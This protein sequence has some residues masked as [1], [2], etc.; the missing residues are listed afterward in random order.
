L[1][2]SHRGPIAIKERVRAIGGQ[3]CVQSKPGQG[4]TLIITFPTVPHSASAQ[5]MS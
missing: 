1:D 3:L 4:A 5:A 2:E